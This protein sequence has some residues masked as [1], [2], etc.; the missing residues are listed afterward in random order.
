M[1][2]VTTQGFA[3]FIPTWQQV[4]YLY[5]QWITVSQPTGHLSGK[6]SGV[7]EEGKL[8][9]ID[10]EGVTHYLFVGDTSLKKGGHVAEASKPTQQEQ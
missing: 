6:A 7:N 5:G 2:H 3:S 9:L 10:E 8:I 1:H 4:D